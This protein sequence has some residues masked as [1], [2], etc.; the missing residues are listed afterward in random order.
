MTQKKSTLF[1]AAIVVLSLSVVGRIYVCLNKNQTQKGIVLNQFYQPSSFSSFYQFG[2]WGADVKIKNKTVTCQM[3]PE[4][5]LY[6]KNN[7]LVQITY[8][9]TFWGQRFFCIFKPIKGD[10]LPSR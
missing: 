3:K 10:F 7:K 4:Q 9:P 8:R 2:W 6:F 1:I 5:F